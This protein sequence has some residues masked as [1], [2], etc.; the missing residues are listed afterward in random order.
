MFSLYSQKSFVINVFTSLY[1]YFA[2]KIRRISI[3]SNYFNVIF[4]HYILVKAAWAHTAQRQGGRLSISTS[5]LPLW[6]LTG[7]RKKTKSQYAILGSW[8]FGSRGLPCHHTDTQEMS[9]YFLCNPGWESIFLKQRGC[10]PKRTHSWDELVNV[11]Q[12][13]RYLLIHF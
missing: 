10:W 7:G 4:Y 3:R 11:Y 6:M 2:T 13:E 1:F 9:G 8:L 12:S 5:R